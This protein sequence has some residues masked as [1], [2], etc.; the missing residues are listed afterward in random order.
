V[1]VINPELFFTKL[2]DSSYLPIE[3][4]TKAFKVVPRQLIKADQNAISA[5][6]QVSD[7]AVWT[8]IAS[9]LTSILL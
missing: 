7:V 8:V 4:G 1:T 3:N 2:P 9:T 5:L 6:E